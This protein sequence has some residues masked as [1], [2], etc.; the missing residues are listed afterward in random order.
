MSNEAIGVVGVDGYTPLYAP[1]ARW[2]MWGIHDI[3]TGGEARNKHIP[4]INDYVIEP[5]TGVTYIVVNLNNV[6]FVPELRPVQIKQDMTVDMITS[7]TT[8]NYRVYYDKSITP[9]T[10]AVDGFMRVYSATASY[11]RIYRG[12]FID[13]TQVISR[14]YDN[15]G[16]FIG[17]D[18]PLQVVAFNSHDNYAIKSVPACNT[19]I[20]L[21]DGE[22]CTVVIFDTNGKVVTKVTCIVDETT[23]IAQAYAEQKYITQIFLKSVFIDTTQSQ[24]I[25]YP[26]N[27][28][29]TSFNPIGVVQYNDG[30]QVEY[31][32]DGDKFRLYGLD[33]FVSTILG[34]RVPLVLSYRMD[35]HE[36]ALASVDTDNAYVTRPYTLV[37]SNPNRSY[38]VKL[39]VY[40]VWVDSVNGYKY[41]AFL[42]NLD[43]NVL[44]DVT[45]LV[46]LATNSPSFN[47]MAYGITQRL[48]FCIELSRV[49][50]IYSTFLHVQ[51]VDII[52]RAPA[53]DSSATNIWEVGSQVPTTVPYFGTNLRA[54]RDPSTGTKIRVGNNLS[55][56]SEFVNKLYRTTMPLF[57]PVTELEAP[58]P[59]HMEVVYLNQ[60]ILAPISGYNGEFIFDNQVP[61][62]ANVEVVFYK[63]TIQGYLKLGVVSLTVR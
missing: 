30:S 23:Y 56:V 37:V 38:N 26:V 1:D 57:N 22:S 15:S 4:K 6:T 49:S 36:S 20:D 53:N 46:T 7:S 41:K 24:D 9:A 5:E 47:P 3:Y 33:Q 12:V 17:H 54:T 14:R 48:T 40:P 51:T 34:H 58:E 8:D 16:N 44:F 32:V 55:T 39:F 63:E 25:N 18:I 13:P 61:Q 2:C 60:A 28:P 52:L 42:M 11:A 27:L 19:N 31:P 59:T 35:A 21:Q 29:V 50:G 45:S 62:Y 10:L 43:R